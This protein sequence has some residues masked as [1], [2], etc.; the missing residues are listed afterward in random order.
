MCVT[1]G[2]ASRAAAVIVAPFSLRF[3]FS[4]AFRCRSS[5]DEAAPEGQY[6]PLPAG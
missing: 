6:L 3:G 5:P 1:D 4:V 2:L